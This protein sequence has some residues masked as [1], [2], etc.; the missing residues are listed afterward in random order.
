MDEYVGSTADNPDSFQ[1][2]L[3]ENLFNHIDIDAKNVYLLNGGAEVPDDECRRYEEKIREVGR[4][5]LL[6]GG[7]FC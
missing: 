3:W 4:I 7:E 6:I 1:H 2:F 5:D